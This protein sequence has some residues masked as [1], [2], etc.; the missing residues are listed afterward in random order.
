MISDTAAVTG[1][2]SLY[3]HPIILVAIPKQS[4]ADPTRFDRMNRVQMLH[5]ASVVFASIPAEMTMC[6]F[7][8][9][10]NTFAGGALGFRS[11]VSTVSTDDAFAVASFADSA[12]TGFTAVVLTQQVASCANT[13]THFRPN[14]STTSLIFFIC[15]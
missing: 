10:Q 3:L 5:T 1:Y 6:S 2:L 9:S 15:I 7:E 11:V 12:N 8:F 13:C 4:T 14:R